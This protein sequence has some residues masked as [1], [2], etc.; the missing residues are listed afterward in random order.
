MFNVRWLGSL[1][2]D[3]QMRH[4]R[5][6]TARG[7]N[8]A[9]PT[10]FA[11]SILVTLASAGCKKVGFW[12]YP[13]GLLPV[14]RQGRAHGCWQAASPSLLPMPL[15]FGAEFLWLASDCIIVVSVERRAHGPTNVQQQAQVEF[16]ALE[17]GGQNACREGY[18]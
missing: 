10:S 12:H 5:R 2:T 14:F 8:N 15:A 17:F 3:R 11:T 6:A 13:Q 9:Q 1:L 4:G 7:Q 16:L 18:R